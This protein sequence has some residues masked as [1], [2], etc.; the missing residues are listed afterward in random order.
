MPYSPTVTDRI[1]KAPKTLGN[2]LGR[3]AVHLDI[4]VTLISS[5][6]GAT[7]QTV[8]NWFSGGEVLQPYRAAVSSL[9]KIM[10]TS[11]TLEEARRRICSAF[12]LPT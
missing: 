8:Y 9:L 2:Q 1:M 6:T 7:R 11:A 3:Y 5:A 4:P 12:T 10:Q